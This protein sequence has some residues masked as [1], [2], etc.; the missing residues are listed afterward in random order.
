MAFWVVENN[1]ANFIGDVRQNFICGQCDFFNFRQ[2][3]TSLYY[4][5]FGWT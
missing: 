5:M 4:Q 3:D 2:N 1:M